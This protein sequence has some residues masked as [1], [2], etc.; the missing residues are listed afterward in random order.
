MPVGRHGPCGHPPFVAHAPRSPVSSPLT[1]HR[2]PRP[3][4][5]TALGSAAVAQAQPTSSGPTSS[6]RIITTLDVQY[7]A[8]ARVGSTVSCVA[9]PLGR[10]MD[11]S[12]PADAT[13]NSRLAAASAEVCLNDAR[14]K[15][16]ATGTITTGWRA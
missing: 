7:S 9:R 11:H 13:S 15:P 12:P 2:I 3:A 5:I 6:G 4:L 1:A 8:T 10:P 14:G 16:I